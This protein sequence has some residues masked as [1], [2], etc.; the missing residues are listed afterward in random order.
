MTIREST[1]RA[2][3]APTPDGDAITPASLLGETNPTHH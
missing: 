2:V 1:A 3:N